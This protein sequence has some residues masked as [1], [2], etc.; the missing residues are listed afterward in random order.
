MEK[1]FKFL[2]SDRYQ[3][4]ES[5]I[6]LKNNMQNEIATFDVFLRTE[7]ENDYAVIYGIAD[8]LELIDVLSDTSYEEK[9]NICQKFW[10]I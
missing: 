3:Y 5:E 2:N 1:F 8:V 4:T 7:K 9:K 10:I 6:Y